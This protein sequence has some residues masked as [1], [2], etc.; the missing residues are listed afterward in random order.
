M[1]YGGN[2]LYTETLYCVYSTTTIYRTNMNGKVTDSQTSNN[3]T[4][5]FT[6]KGIINE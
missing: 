1:V 5:Q 4:M 6:N 3:C 2:G